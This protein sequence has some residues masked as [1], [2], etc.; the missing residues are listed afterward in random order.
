MKLCLMCDLHLPAFKDALQ[1]RVLDWAL[2]DMKSHSPDAVIFAGDVTCDGQYAV[3]H[4]FLETMQGLPCPFI[5]IPGNSDLR[6]EKDRDRLQ[7]MSSPIVNRLGK[8]RVF[9]VNDCTRHISADTLA[10][11]AKAE[12]NDLVFMHHPIGDLAEASK[13]AMEDWQRNHPQVHLIYGHC[14]R[15]Q[16]NGRTIS[17]QAMDP[18]KAISSCPAIA[19]FDTETQQLCHSYFEAPIP[20]DLEAYLGISCYDTFSHIQYAVDHRL[21][22]LELRPNIA[23]LDENALFSAITAWRKAGGINLGMHFTDIIYENGQLATPG[24]DRLIELANLLHADR[25]TQ[26]VPRV[27]LGIIQQEPDVLE[28]ICRRLAEKFNA[29][30]HPVV[31]GLENMHMTPGETPDAARRFGYLPEECLAY[32][33]CLGVKCRH[34]VGI[35]FDIGHARNNLPFSQNYQISSWLAL[36]GRYTVGFHLHQVI[37]D[38]EGYHNH[39][40]FTEPYGRLISLASFFRSWSD[41][42]LK[43]APIILEMRPK[44]AYDISLQTL[45]PSLSASDQ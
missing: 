42:T 2:K 20:D 28:A 40:A 37:L 35:H 4:R 27:S 8:L 5:Y 39:T 41:G 3:F 7:S 1:Y 30:T 21:P 38:R 14:H 6:K 22:M 13:R 16:I 9:A 17:L 43:K 31:I 11:L 18:D 34:H 12:P 29:I 44:D 32:M 26:H 15:L 10:A 36:V 45:C 19:Y 33:H 24:M 23:G 25:I